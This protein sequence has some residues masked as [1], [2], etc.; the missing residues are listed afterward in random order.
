[1]QRDEKENW[2]YGALCQEFG[3]MTDDVPVAGHADYKMYVSW[4]RPF[5]I[6]SHASLDR[7]T[8]SEIQKNNWKVHISIDPADL[9]RAWDLVFPILAAN[10]CD[11]FKV[12]ILPET[13]RDM[14]DYPRQTG[15]RYAGGSESMFAVK[16]SATGDIQQDVRERFPREEIEAATRIGQGMQITVYPVPGQESKIRTALYEIENILNAEGIRPGEMDKSDYPVG[17]FCSIRHTGFSHGGYTPAHLAAHYNPD[18]ADESFYPVADG[19]F[20]TALIMTM[21]GEDVEAKKQIFKTLP[22]T[23]QR[24][25]NILMLQDLMRIIKLHMLEPEV[26][27]RAAR[28]SLFSMRGD[29]LK[30][31]IKS[32]KVRALELAGHEAAIS[33]VQNEAMMEILSV[34]Q[35]PLDPKMPAS[36]RQY[37]RMQKDGVITVREPDHPR[38][39]HTQKK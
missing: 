39:P 21:K 28:S 23:I 17:Q 20:I 1:M 25:D 8:E 12:T 30:K 24:I 36:L 3:R 6:F 26:N 5:V 32:V 14:E 9:G 18:N 33:T 7:E 16:M 22:H 4:P 38:R 34:K 27:R 37:L 19:R 2:R 31:I 29:S 10:G 35:N 15:N 11:L 13:Y